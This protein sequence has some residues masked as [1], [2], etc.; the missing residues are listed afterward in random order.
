LEVSGRAQIF[1]K[2]AY[3]CVIDRTGVF[4]LYLYQF[5]LDEFFD[6][7]RNRGLRVI[8]V[9]DDVFVADGNALGVAFYDEAVNFNARGMR[10]GVGYSRDQEDFFFLHFAG[11]FPDSHKN[12]RLSL[13]L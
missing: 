10:Q 13:D 1:F 9:C 4:P 5:C 8:E 6:M 7:L 3:V 2:N 12:T 11:F